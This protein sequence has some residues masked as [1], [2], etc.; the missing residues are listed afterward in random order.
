MEY[1]L[2]KIIMTARARF[3]ITMLKPYQ[4][5]VIQR[6]LEQEDSARVRHQLV[7]LPTGTGKSACFLIP[8]TLCKGITIIVY[9]LL[10]LMNDQMS[11][12]RKAGIDCVCIRGGQ[13]KQQREEI[14]AR[15]GSGTKI[16]VTTPES[17]GGTYVMHRLSR[18]PI[19]LLVV[20]EAHVISQW[21]K[22]FRPSYLSL[23]D[24]VMRLHP[25]QILAFTAT[26][27]DQ[28]IR[29]IRACLFFSRPLIVRGDIDRP[30]I[31]YRSY[32]TLSRTQAVVEL[33]R[34]CRRPAVVFCRTRG[35][36]Q[37]L[38]IRLLMET[39][40]IPVRYYHA[41]LTREEREALEKW[42]M[43]SS[44]GIL[45][46]TCAFGMGVD[47]K[48]IRTV[49]HHRLPGT[50]EEYLQESGR[51]GR[52]GETSDAWVIVTSDDMAGDTPYSPVLETF[53]PPR[54]GHPETCR[55]RS[56]LSAMGQ[57]KDECTGCDVCLGEQRKEMTAQ[58]QL[59]HLIRRWPFRF[60]DTVASFLLCG[61]KN[62]DLIR[63]EDIMNPLFGSVRGWNPKAFCQTIKRLSSEESAFPLSGISYLGST[64]S[65]NGKLLYPSGKSLY[66]A[67]ASLLRRI[68]NGYRWI[69]RKTDFLRHRDKGRGGKKVHEPGGRT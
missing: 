7:I 39:R 36:T 9:P 65:G 12:L 38:C 67:I 63:Y 32:P 25:H 11:R 55:R 66:N 21:G 64:G 37:R 54:D 60:D 69:V 50:Y 23:T 4:I 20:D 26:A 53:R 19:S 62:T 33:A 34:T 29:D 13:T 14:F 17:L 31:I 27:T 56:I 68:D 51:A 3:G 42:F 6:I 40:G 2:D 59:M 58:R 43:D 61:M 16:V 30:N 47:K 15:L 45:C 52:D 57:E 46:S 8:A 1:Y 18:L 22:G 48:D 28:T 5:L 49:I 44:D 35:D 24:A 10:A 41:G